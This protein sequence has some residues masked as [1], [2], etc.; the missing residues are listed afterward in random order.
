MREGL[1]ADLQATLGPPGRAGSTPPRPAVLVFHFFA[2]CPLIRWGGAPKI[3]AASPCKHAGRTKLADSAF[4]L[5]DLPASL[6]PGH[7][8]TIVSEP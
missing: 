4:V 2:G 8:F 7:V 3:E 5:V 6:S 1:S